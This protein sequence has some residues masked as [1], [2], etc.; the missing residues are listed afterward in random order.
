VAEAGVIFRRV[1]QDT[2]SM[3][4]G[5]SVQQ[6]RDDIDSG[7]FTGQNQQQLQQQHQLPRVIL[8]SETPGSIVRLP[9]LHSL[10][11]SPRT[12]TITTLGRPSI[13]TPEHAEWL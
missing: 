10:I 9:P 7:I 11:E 2:D 13:A 12:E 5:A 8:G 3:D 4:L 6:I 1:R